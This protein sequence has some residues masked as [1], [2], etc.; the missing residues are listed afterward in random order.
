MATH[1]V[2][3]ARFSFN[4][5]VVQLSDSARNPYVAAAAVRARARLPYRAKSP[6][7]LIIKHI[8]VRAPA[9]RLQGRTI[10]AY[11]TSQ[12]EWDDRKSEREWER[13]E[14]TKG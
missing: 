11:R 14:G 3:L 9:A 8:G 1:K 4:R 10:A 7:W 13:Y 2:P 5:E 6:A 12:L